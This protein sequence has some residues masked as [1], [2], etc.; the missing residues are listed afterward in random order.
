MQADSLFSEKNNGNFANNVLGILFI[1]YGIAIT[2]YNVLNIAWNDIDYITRI[3]SIVTFIL[4]YWFL[5]ENTFP[6]L[7]NL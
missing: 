2:G 3:S 4:A 7:K 6:T 1:G 5:I